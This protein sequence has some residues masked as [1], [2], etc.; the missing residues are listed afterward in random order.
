MS[1]QKGFFFVT[2]EVDR[3]ELA[4][5]PWRVPRNVLQFRHCNKNELQTLLS[6]S[7]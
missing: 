4:G 3:V 1:G 7:A 6:G 5:Q 2:M